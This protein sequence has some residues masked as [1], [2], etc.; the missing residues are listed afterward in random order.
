MA[1]VPINTVNSLKY[2]DGLFIECNNKTDLLYHVSVDASVFSSVNWY[3]L[4]N[5]NFASRWIIDIT[6]TSD[7]TIQGAAFPGIV[8]RVVYNILGSGRTIHTQNG[9]AGHIF[10]PQNIFNQP[11]GVTYGLVVAGDIVIAKQNNKPNCKNFRPVAITTK[12]AVGVAQG[13]TIIYVIDFPDFAVGDRICIDSDCHIIKS[14]FTS[15]NSA[16]IVLET[17]VEADHASASF[18]VA[19]VSADDARTPMAYPQATTETTAQTSFDFNTSLS[20]SLQP[21]VLLLALA[22]LVAY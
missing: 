18:I 16:A 8:E 15:D 10:A 12:L 1:A 19:L 21:L 13:S 9:V 11:T 17:P 20:T 14:G 2:G 22:H 6:G 4:N 5:C 3:S 7:V